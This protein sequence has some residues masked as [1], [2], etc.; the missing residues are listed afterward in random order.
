MKRLNLWYW[1]VTG[2]FAA[3]MLFSAIPN[4]LNTKESVDFVATGLGYPKYM[5]PFLGWAKAFGVIAILIPQFRRLKEWAYA[6]L[7]FD[8]LGAVYSVASVNG[9][10]PSLAVMILPISF[11]FISYYLWH[12]KIA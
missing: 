2:L 6:G 9:I 10:Q 12:K 3:F 11:L 8:L 4:I 5:I 1:I 7:L